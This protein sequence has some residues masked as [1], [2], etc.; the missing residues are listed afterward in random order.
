MGGPNVWLILG[1]DIGWVR[2]L[3][4]HS[5]WLKVAVRLRGPY[6]VVIDSLNAGWEDCSS[7]CW[8]IIA[9]A[10]TRLGDA[11]LAKRSITILA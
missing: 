3:P 9:T 11:P 8:I 2:S 6:E 10:A 4:H 7:I 1:S 5:P